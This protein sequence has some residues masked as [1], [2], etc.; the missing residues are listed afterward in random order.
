MK[1]P[2]IEY[3]FYTSLFLSIITQIAGA[4]IISLRLLI[5]SVI[6]LLLAQEE[7]KQRAAK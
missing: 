7:I 5:W 4:E 6:F 1:A 3:V 2:F